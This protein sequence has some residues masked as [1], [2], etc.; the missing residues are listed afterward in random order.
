[1]GKVRSL[2][3]PHLGSNSTARRSP[4]VGILNGLTP[5][6]VVQADL[7]DRAIPFEA[8]W[9]SARGC[10]IAIKAPIFV[11]QKKKKKKNLNYCI[12]VFVLY[13]KLCYTV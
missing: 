9:R 4:L 5:H 10:N 6:T 8:I 3:A 7:R 12:A 11:S 1:M 13:I 2:H